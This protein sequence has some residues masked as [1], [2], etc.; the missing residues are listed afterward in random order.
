MYSKISVLQFSVLE[1]SSIL[2]HLTAVLVFAY[3][4]PAGNPVAKQSQS[5]WD[6]TLIM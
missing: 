2:F 6:R 4:M 3:S 1:N 5:E